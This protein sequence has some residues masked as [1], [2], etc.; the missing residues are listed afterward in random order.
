M[1]YTLTLG[2]VDF[3]FPHPPAP[4]L[5]NDNSHETNLPNIIDLLAS[6]TSLRR[7]LE[8][9]LTDCQTYDVVDASAANGF[10]VHTSEYTRT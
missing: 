6:F 2:T 7:H 8:L 10:V 3:A 4:N 1:I 9:Q 5:F